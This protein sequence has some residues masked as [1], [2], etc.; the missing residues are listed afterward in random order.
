MVW[1]RRKDIVTKILIVALILFVFV[2]LL[3]IAHVGTYSDSYYDALNGEWIYDTYN[4]N[5]Y[6][7][8]TLGYIFVPIMG[9]M[10]LILL[11]F[12]IAF[13][14][15]KLKYIK[16]HK[17]MSA[18][19]YIVLGLAAVFL[20]V[21]FYGYGST[22]TFLGVVV[23]LMLYSIAI[24]AFFAAGLSIAN[25]IVMLKEDAG[26]KEE[27]AIE[28]KNSNLAIERLTMLKKLLDSGAITTEEYN[29]KKKKYIDLL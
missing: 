25:F 9:G 2:S 23:M 20:T 3:G 13:N 26:N 1:Y 29:E 12:T 28:I 4:F 18:V 11:P 16:L 19:D 10:I 27:K 8:R 15:G 17:F 7:W 6:Y 5:L 22:I 24:G 21:G 14:Y